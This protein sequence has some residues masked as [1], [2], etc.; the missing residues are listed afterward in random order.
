VGLFL[1]G[2]IV[3]GFMLRALTSPSPSEEGNFFC[4]VFL[5]ESGCSG[6]FFA[7]LSE[8]G[9]SGLEDLLDFLFHF[10]QDL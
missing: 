2:V 3:D 10:E 7:Y 8:S 5:S 9:F 6:F 1:F 4:G